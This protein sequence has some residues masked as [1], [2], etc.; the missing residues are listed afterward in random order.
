MSFILYD[1]TLLGIFVVF[2]VLF[3]YRGR[4]NTKREGILFLYRTE[5][6]MKLIE[7]VGTK[8]K[9]TLDFLS[10]ISVGLGYL[11][12]IGALWLVYTIVK[13]YLLRPD[14]VSAIKVPPIMPLIPYIDKMVPFLPPFYFTYWIAILAVIAI[15]HEFAH[16]IFMRRY[17]IKIKS[18]GFGFFPFFF[19]VFP[20][21]FVEQDEKSMIKANNFEQRAVLSAGTFANMITAGV[22]LIVLFGFFALNFTP[23]GI[24][25]D[26][27]SYNVVNLS[28]ITMVNGAQINNPSM[29][30]LKTVVKNNTFNNIEAGGT[31]FIGIK[32]FSNDGTQIAL[33]H[34]APAIKSE[35][36]G[37][38]IKINNIKITN[39]EELSETLS[40]HNPGDKVII[41]TKVKEEIQEYEIILGENPENPGQVWLGIGFLNKPSSSGIMN[42]IFGVISSF[43]LSNVYYESKIGEFGWFIYYLLW[44]LIMMSLSVALINMLPMGIFDGGRFFYLTVLA[45]TGK[46]TWAKNS[47]KCLT[48]L[49]L[50]ILLAIM[51][52]W[53][54]VIFF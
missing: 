33:Y 36:N 16:G 45:I 23:G 40:K 49:F 25:F 1:L 12:T 21:A 14:V 42:K 52:F 20:A 17:G 39:L 46:E 19:P 41:K 7:K 31:N 5:W 9:K 32:G 47:Y 43:K 35:L 26:D 24:V 44:W 30:E 27:Y 37:A 2:V 38:I 11:L 10:Y 8:Y 28:A 3:L 4:K 51:V 50:I 34:D 53:A 18:T 22:F 29:D 48:Y 13:L 54:Y 6:G 15:T